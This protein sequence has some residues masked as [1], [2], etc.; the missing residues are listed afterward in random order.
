[1]AVS[2]LAVIPAAPVWEKLGR[3]LAPDGRYP[4][5]STVTGAAFAVPA[6]DGALC[7]IYV[8]GR[9]DKNRTRIGKIRID[10][11]D[12]ARPA[13]IGAQAVLALGELG[14]FDENGTGY[15]CLVPHEGRM[16]MYYVGWMPTVLTP[17]QNHLGL[18]EQQADGNF[19]RVSRAPVLERTDDDFLS[20]GSSYVLGDEGRFR[21]WY[22]SYVKW[23]ETP[24]E[25]KHTYLIKYAESED[26]IHWK[27][28]GQ[29]C[30]G[31][32]HPLEFAICRPSVLKSGGHYHMWY[33]T[34]GEKYRIGY[35]VSEDGLRW[36]RRD[37]LA[38][39]APSG[40]GWDSH[41]VAYPHVFECRGRL[42]ML[43]CGNDYGRQGLGLARLKQ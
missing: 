21:M 14:A 20:M 13:E 22:T 26:G 9:D 41:A 39:I 33:A 2:E 6:G 3:I 23:G 25:P 16:R 36:S 19:V 7:D 11:E 5:M 10:L 31:P 4:W 24:D 32:Q 8:A 42:Y 37:D 34:R 29:I 30:I 38:G 12:L 43:Y 35:A 27:R 28:E 1:M 17:C 18:A 40:K 15:P